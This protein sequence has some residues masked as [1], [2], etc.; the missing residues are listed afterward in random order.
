MLARGPQG[1]FLGG[2]EAKD[3]WQVY[4]FAEVSAAVSLDSNL[5]VRSE[6]L[7]L[8]DDLCASNGAV[9]GLP[10]ISRAEISCLF[11]IRGSDRSPVDGDHER[12]L[13][14]GT[15]ENVNVNMWNLA[16]LNAEPHGEQTTS[17][18]IVDFI[19]KSF[20]LPRAFLERFLAERGVPRLRLLPPYREHLSQAFARF[21]MRVGLPTPVAP[22]W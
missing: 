21:F 9:P 11:D 2:A 5:I 15:F 6:G 4:H 3:G 17:H 14:N 7:R 16:M 10:G 18:R 12:L 20:S 22:A 19:T 1:G 8:F 13:R